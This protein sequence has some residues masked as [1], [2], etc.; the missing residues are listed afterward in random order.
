[1]PHKFIARSCLILALGAG[2]FDLVVGLFAA[3]VSV[4][5]VRQTEVFISGQ[6]GYHT[7]R[8]PAVITTPKGTVLAFCEGRKSG[9]SDTGDIDV[10]LKRSFDGGKTWQNLQTVWDDGANTCGNPCPVIDRETGT[11]WLP[12]TH[13][14]GQDT[15]SQIQSRTSQGSR[16]VWI[17]KSTDDGA[18]WTKP[19][20]I[21]ASVKNPDWTWY[22]TG[23]GVGIQMSG[24]RLIIPCD[25]VLADSKA[26]NAHVI[27]SD[28]HGRSWKL[29]GTAGPQCN[30]CQIAELSN[31]SLQLNMR[32]YHGKNCRAVATSK[33]GGVTWSEATLDP[34]LIEPVCQASL[35]RYSKTQEGGKSW[36]LF[37]NPAS[38]KRERMT[39]RL[40]RDDGQS[41]PSSGLLHAGP[42]AYSCL[43]VLSDG[44]IGCLYER[45]EKSPYERITFA[46]FPVQWL[47]A[48]AP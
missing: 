15:E 5:A 8:I 25:H 13:N 47:R 26:R 31:G 46:T 39:V 29:G 28:D 16:T 6:D 44:S 19:L 30:E 32:S 34:A 4:A 21:T 17:T 3:E 7:F 9:R 2:H 40:S 20:E 24:G 23:P 33:D 11:T 18:T 36:L 48:A 38:L 22:A 14:L 43:T 27:Y 45:G 35:L 41:W 10:V 37:S 12:L 42:S 1:M